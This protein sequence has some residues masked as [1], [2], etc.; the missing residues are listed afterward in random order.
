MLSSIHPFGERAR[1]QRFLVTAT[2]YSIGCLIGGLAMGALVSAPGRLFDYSL[3]GAALIIIIVS[4]AIEISDH[5]LP[6][7]ARQVDEDWLTRYRGWVYG[8][9]YGFQLG[10]GFAT[11]VK[12]P[13]TYGF[14]VAAILF[15]DPKTALIAGTAFGAARACSIAAV[16]AVSSPS[17][18]A[19]LFRNLVRSR[20]P[21][22]VLSAI[23]VAAV[24]LRGMV[25]VLG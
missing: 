3:A 5:E 8:V 12:T 18:L 13:L 17:R 23:G 9:G 25:E 14:V 10:F 2:W 11:Y 21:V 22:Q 4:A 16:G 24:G 7:L 1:A 6:S 20:R 19:A 15:G